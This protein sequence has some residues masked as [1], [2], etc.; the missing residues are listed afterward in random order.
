MKFDQDRAVAR[1]KVRLVIQGF[2]QQIEIDY[3]KT[4][5]PIAKLTTIKILLTIAVVKK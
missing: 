2:T 3:I 4:F 5:S 1:H